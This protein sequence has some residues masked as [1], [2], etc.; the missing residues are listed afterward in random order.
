MGTG[1][2]AEATGWVFRFSPYIGRA[3]AIH[4]AIAD[5]VNDQYDYEFW[6]SQGRLATK[7]RT[8]TP[9]VRQTVNQMIED[10]MLTELEGRG[11]D[12]GGKDVR[13]FRLEM[14]VLEAVYETR[15]GGKPA[16]RPMESHL[17]LGDVPN[18]KP[19]TPNGKPATSQWK[20]SHVPNGKPL[21]TNPIGTQEEPK[22]D[23][24]AEAKKLEATR[25]TGKSYGFDRAWER[26]PANH[27]GE[28]PRKAEAA[29]KWKTLS[30]PTKAAAYEGIKRLAVAAGR[31]DAS[32]TPAMIVWL[33]R[34]QWEDEAVEAPTAPLQ[35]DWVPQEPVQEHNTPEY[36][37]RHEAAQAAAE[38]EKAAEAE[39]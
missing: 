25:G 22:R 36:W 9:T 15:G 34:R 33:R 7:A 10:G 11:G 3:F 27:R 39:G 21:T 5:S 2:S 26:F 16:A 4:L 12:R 32:Y 23:A 14:P 17:P 30:Y 18:G 13:R 29:E 6:M 35:P 28:R 37:A 24:R 38:A 31:P 20:A 1:V 19:A 8:T